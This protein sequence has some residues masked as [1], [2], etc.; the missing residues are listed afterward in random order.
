MGLDMQRQ[1]TVFRTTANA[2]EAA[3]DIDRL[4]I[5]A[6]EG[7]LKNSEFLLR[8]WDKPDVCHVL[9]IRHLRF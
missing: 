9:S 5:E 1:S 8:I 4:S 3:G 6:L 2:F 7:R